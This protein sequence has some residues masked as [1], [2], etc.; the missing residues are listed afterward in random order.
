MA[1]ASDDDLPLSLELPVDDKEPD[2]RRNKASGTFESLQRTFLLEMQ[3]SSI[4]ACLPISF[5]ELCLPRFASPS[6]SGTSKD[7]SSRGLL[8]R[9]RRSLP[10]QR[11]TPAKRHVCCHPSC[12]PPVCPSVCPVVM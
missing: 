1:S 12:C 6:I 5:N 11:E 4:V 2:N 3:V 7:T 8:Q 10:Q 9:T